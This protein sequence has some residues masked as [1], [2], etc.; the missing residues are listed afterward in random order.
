MN[1]ARPG[2]DRARRE[3]MKA[4]EASGR[5]LRRRAVFCGVVLLEAR[6]PAHPGRSAGAG[7]GR[8][9]GALVVRAGSGG[10]GVGQP[11]KG[12]H[13]SGSARGG[14]AATPGCGRPAAVRGSPVGL[15]RKSGGLLARGALRLARGGS[16]VLCLGPGD[17]VTATR[18]LKRVVAA[19]SDSWSGRRSRGS[20]PGLGGRR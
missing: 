12:G 6:I 19:S 10:Q 9:G 2:V 4:R 11:C 5:W 7:S 15:W 1:G 13:S 20:T 17:Q 3:A 16:G 8:E 18:S 14:G